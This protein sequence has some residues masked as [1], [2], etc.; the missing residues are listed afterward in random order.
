MKADQ[1]KLYAATITAMVTVIGG[2]LLLVYVAA[3]PAIEDKAGLMALLG[4]F[5]GA[6]ITFLFSQESATGAVRSYERGLNTPAPGSEPP[7]P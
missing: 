6:G 2:A 3:T 1:I 5:T 7:T 4:G